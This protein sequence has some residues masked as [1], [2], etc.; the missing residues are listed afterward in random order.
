MG[1]SGS[2]KTTLGRRLSGALGLPFIELDA[3]NWQAGWYDLNQ[4]DPAEFIRRVETAL[5]PEA[6]VSDGNYGIVRKHIW[7]RATDLVWL[8]Y[9]RSVIMPRVIGRSVARALDRKELWP[10]TGNREEWRQWFT[11]KDHPIRWAWRTHND[12]RRRL[13]ITLG[14]PGLGHLRIHRLR[15]PREAEGLVAALKTENIS[16]SRP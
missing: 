9:D 16:S 8:D 15:H 13:E 5:A 14:E 3:I 7:S 4:N 6:W 1:T 11:D 2:G 12:R 10:G